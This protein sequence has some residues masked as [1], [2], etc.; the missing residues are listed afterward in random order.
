[1]LDHRNQQLDLIAQLEEKCSQL[2]ESVRKTTF[3]ELIRHCHEA[4]SQSLKVACP[5][6]CAKGN[7]QGPKGRFCPERFEHWT[8]CTD[9]QSQIYRSVCEFL[10]P[11]ES[12]DKRLFKSIH[13][14][15][16]HEEEAA[17]SPISS[18]KG[19]ENY[20]KS[21]V[22]LHVTR[23]MEELYKIP[24]AR[25]R[26][27][28][29]G[30]GIQFTD[31]LNPL[32][33]EYVAQ[34]RQESGSVS[35]QMAGRRPDTFCVHYTDEKPGL[36]TTVDYKPPYK[37]SMETLR[38]GLRPV[39]FIDEIINSSPTSTEGKATR[40]AGS[41]I[42]QEYHAMIELGL[43]Y[44]Y[45]S[46]GLGLVLLRIPYDNPE[47]LYYHL[48]EP[49]ADADLDNLDW[50]QEP[51]TMIARIL[52]LCLM[53]FNSPIRSQEWRAKTKETLAKWNTS[54]DYE[55][56]VQNK[57][58]ASE[59]R[60][61]SDVIAPPTR[62]NRRGAPRRSPPHTKS[63]TRKLKDSG[64][65]CAEPDDFN[66]REDESG[67]D[68]DPSTGQ[69]RRRGPS[70]SIEFSSSGQQAKRRRTSQ[71]NQSGRQAQ[72]TVQFCTQKCLLGLKK[73][74]KL[75]EKCPN[76]TLHR[77]HGSSKWHP[78]SSTGLVKLLKHQLNECIDRAIPLGECGA[79]GAPFQLTCERF[80]YTVVGKGTSCW[81]WPE[82]SEEAEVYQVLSPAQGSVVPVFLGKIDLDKTYFLHGAGKIRHMILMAWGGKTID[83]VDVH[84]RIRR[85]ST[86][87]AVAEIDALGVK[88]EDI[89]DANVLWNTELDRAMVID[90]HICQLKAQVVK[91]KKKTRKVAGTRPCNYHSTDIM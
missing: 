55:H 49:N 44:G 64:F 90:F 79:S 85:K 65:R 68:A 15:R 38:I 87:R 84:P 47:T 46:T 23:I 41:A 67:P 9:A 16:E 50:P 21:T 60:R 77:Q 18:E 48:C 53:S 72:R 61:G 56:E 2:Q 71:N 80:G 17:M 13:N 22:V 45:V 83:R 74:R 33:T 37:L 76:V 40:L 75:D 27:G 81:L 89:R 57:D 6:L 24:A 1:M 8:G 51:V 54:F 5:A 63:R 69:K 12:S 62:K 10:A 52:C 78:T 3:L 25:E 35:Q 26:F 43:E 32:G 31:H 14:I 30:T 86:K 7:I 29:K 82:V 59:H 4:L 11:S 42:V 73:R 36:L 58:S 34:N 91:K 19:L 66:F 39:A 70:T 20:M 28:L 88:H